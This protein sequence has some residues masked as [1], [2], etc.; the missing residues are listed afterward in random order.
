MIKRMGMIAA[1]MVLFSA[2]LVAWNEGSEAVTFSNEFKL[3]LLCVVASI[4]GGVVW[5]AMTRD[6]DNWDD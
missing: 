4:V 6:T 5:Y 1:L 3:I 2:Y